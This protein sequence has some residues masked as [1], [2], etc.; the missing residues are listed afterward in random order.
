MITPEAQRKG[1]EANREAAKR[2][3]GT[4]LQLLS[5]GLTYDEIATELG[6]TPTTVRTVILRARRRAGIRVRPYPLD[7]EKKP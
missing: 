3:D 6:V 7:Q 5:K 1:A 4:V 2:R